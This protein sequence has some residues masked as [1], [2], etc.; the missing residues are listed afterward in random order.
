M[1]K[2]ILVP[3]DG[4][5]LAEKALP[6]AKAL[7]QKFEAKL[8]LLRVL[9]TVLRPIVVMSSYG[10]VVDNVPPAFQDESE[11][12]LSKLYLKTVLDKFRLP[13]RIRVI[14]GFPEADA[15]IDF[16]G[17]E[18]MD[19]IVMSTHG[20]SGIS[21]WVYGSVAEKILHHTPC[22]VL[23]ARAKEARC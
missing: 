2:K 23:L 4:S 11:I 5:K 13:A 14:E 18:L 20:R 10:D 6:Y 7:A 17:Q 1:I 9:Q 21:R 3:L 19:L 8:I 12:N 16:A 15:I 22:P